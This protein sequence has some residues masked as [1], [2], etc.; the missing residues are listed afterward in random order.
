LF[1]RRVN[2]TVQRREPDGSESDFN[3]ADIT[4]F[5]C[6]ACRKSPAHRLHLSIASKEKIKMKTIT[7]RLFVFAATAVFLGTT[8][9]GQTTMRADVP[10]A[11]HI[12]GGGVDA[13]HYDVRLENGGTGKI[14]T[15]HNNDSHRAAVAVTFQLSA[16]SG[17]AIH[18]RLVFRCGDTGC[19][20]SEVWTADGGY[21]IPQGKP[22]AHEYLASIPLA[23][24][25]GN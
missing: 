17:E 22:R 13:G 3:Q 15:V 2:V 6:F 11:F 9:F 16:K 21:G 19:A 5:Q 10:F 20:L 4:C 14:V 8:A 23:V 7:N 25:H 1:L 18:P 12:T 24:Q